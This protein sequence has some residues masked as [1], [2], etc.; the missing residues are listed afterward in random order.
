MQQIPIAL[1]LSPVDFGP[2]LDQSLLRPREAPAQALERVQGE[3]RSLFLVLRV[4]VPPVMR[5]TSA[6]EHPNDDARESR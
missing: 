3:D 6:E 4:E 1:E 2:C 5:I